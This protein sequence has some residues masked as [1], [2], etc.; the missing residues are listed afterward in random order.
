MK[1]LVIGGNRFFGRRLVSMLLDSGGEV[2]V[3]NRGNL[4]DDFG[5]QVKRIRL[6][7]KQL[8]ARHPALENGAWDMVYDQACYDAHEAQGACDAFRGRVGYYVFTSSQSVYKTG[9]RIRESEVDPFH[10]QFES[11]IDRDPDYGEAKRQAEAVFCREFED[12]VSLVR[13]PIVLGEDDY[14][15]RLKFHVDHVRD[16]KPM[17]FPCIEGR[18]SFIY[19]SDAAAFLA[20]LSRGPTVG[21]VNCC[22]K[23]PIRLQ[24]LIQLVEERVGRKAEIVNRPELGDASPYGIEN[25][26]YMDTSKLDRLGFQPVEIEEGL[27]PLLDH[28]SKK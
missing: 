24:R 19:A 11:S 18:I 16:G 15:G 6:D 2:T 7:R 25:D 21:P 3:L 13:F 10:Y 12:R 27:L 26:W 9:Q 28:L 22:A 8:G 17:Y 4:S 14:T 20:R 1:A 5:N 23:N